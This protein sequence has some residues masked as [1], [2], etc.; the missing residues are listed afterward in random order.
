LLQALLP[1]G[2]RGQGRLRHFSRCKGSL[3]CF[4][5]GS[6]FSQAW[7]LAYRLSSALFNDAKA[8]LA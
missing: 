6:K 5:R 4:C 8:E 1:F 7:R 2:A 3:R